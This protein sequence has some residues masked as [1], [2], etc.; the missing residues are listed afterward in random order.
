VPGLLD[1]ETETMLTAIGMA[2]LLWL[3]EP[4]CFGG[5]CATGGFP[6]RWNGFGW[7]WGGNPSPRRSFY[8]TIFTECACTPGQMA[9]GGDNWAFQ[10]RRGGYPDPVPGYAPPS[11]TSPTNPANPGA[12]PPNARGTPANTDSGSSN[13]IP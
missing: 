13:P 2:C 4:G 11:I 6:V 5:D 3:P 7:G 1:P 9:P 10:M 12:T 8:S